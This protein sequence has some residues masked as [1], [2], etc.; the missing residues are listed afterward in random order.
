M[1]AEYSKIE[2]KYKKQRD[3]KFDMESLRKKR[4]VIEG[5]LDECAERANFNEYKNK[6]KEL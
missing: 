3:F 4:E 1:M 6:V 5:Q 2:R